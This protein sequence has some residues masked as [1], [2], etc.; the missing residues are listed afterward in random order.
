MFGPL[1]KVE[2]ANYH[3]NQLEEIFSRYIRA[4]VK[5]IR[6]K[7]NANTGKNLRQFGLKLPLHTPT[8]IG[9]AVHNLRVSLDHAYYILVDSIGVVDET[10]RKYIKFPFCYT[11]EE[12][13][14]TL[15]GH[16][17]TFGIEK[18]ISNFIINEIEPFEGGK[19]NLYEVN[20]LDITDKHHL[21]L[22]TYRKFDIGPNTLKIGGKT[23]Q[24]VE[25]TSF[26]IKHPSESMFSS[27]GPIEYSGNLQ[28]S[29][30]I[31]FGE[32]EMENSPVL[33]TL[34]SLSKNIKSSIIG[35]EA[36]V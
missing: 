26:I 18:N 9:D 11:K 12:A 24:G 21:L 10:S 2:R 29:I 35:L 8:V 34:S 33:E 14:G 30:S 13:I 3:I 19:L 31:L 4:N 7:R 23:L 20:R 17:K 1:L 15:K 6:G 16:S 22:P 27:D 36:F 32:G 28:E 5:S 25:G